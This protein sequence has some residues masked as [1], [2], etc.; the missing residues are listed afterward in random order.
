MGNR[1]YMYLETFYLKVIVGFVLWNGDITIF[2]SEEGDNTI[3]FLHSLKVF[4]C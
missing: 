3:I 4:F 1:Q 2:R